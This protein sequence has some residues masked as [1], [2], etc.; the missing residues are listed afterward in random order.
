MITPMILRI[1]AVILGAGVL[2]CALNAVMWKIRKNW[3]Q[4]RQNEIVYSDTAVAPEHPSDIDEPNHYTYIDEPSSSV[5]PVEDESGYMIPL[6]I[7]STQN[8]SDASDVNVQYRIPP[9]TRF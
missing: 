5:R 4:K 1:L 9:E 6:D 2:I 7:R 3:K 8:D